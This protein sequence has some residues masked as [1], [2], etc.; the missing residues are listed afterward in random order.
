MSRRGAA[1]DSSGPPAPVKRLTSR[2]RSS[3]PPGVGFYGYFRNREALLTEMLDTWERAV[4]EEAIK[5]V[6]E[7]GGDARTRLERLFALVASSAPTTSMSIELAIREWARRDKDLARRV[8]RVD[9][10]RT[11]YLRSLF[12]SFC[13][14]DT[15]VEVRCLVA[16]SLRIGN[17]LIPADHAGHTR[18]EV[19]EA[20]KKW[21]LG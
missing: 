9:N 16:S 20:A 14:D 2:A 11:A 7:G 5:R 17:Y 13:A 18:A 10:R 15:E 1:A 12:A 4:T 3:A 19:M 21:L 6:E 8:R